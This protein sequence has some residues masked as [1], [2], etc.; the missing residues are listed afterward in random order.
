MTPTLLLYCLLSL[1]AGSAITFGLF[2]LNETKRQAKLKEESDRLLASIRQQAET[3]RSQLMVQ[4]KEAALEIKTTAEEE[5]AAARKSQLLREQK[6]DRRDEQLQQQEDSLR[7]QQRGLEMSQTRLATQ[8]RGLTDQRAQLEKTVKEQTAVLEQASGMTRDQAAQKLMEALEKELEN[9]RGTALLRHKKRL[10]EVVQAQGREMLLTAIQRYASAHTAES[11]TS[12]VDVPTDDMKGRI[13]GREGRNIRAFEKATGVDVIIDDTPGV[14][15]VSGFDPV[16]REIA[17]QSLNSLIADGR[18]HPSKI[19]EIVEETTKKI[20]DVILQKGREAADEVNVPG[21]PQKIL[22]MLGRLHFRTSYS[23]N[24]LR[25][26]VEVAF[27]SGLVAEMLGMDADL[28]RR[29]GLLHDIG[30]AA[31]HELEGGHPKI[32]ADLLRR[33]NEPAEVVHAALGHHDEIVTEYPYTMLVAIGDACSA[34][35]PGARRES[36]ERYVKRMEELES[37]AGRFDG[38]RQAFAISAGRELRVIVSSDKTTDEQAATI[39]RNIA[40]AFESELTYPGEIKVTVVRESRFT[41][42]AH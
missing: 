37:I 9:E 3:E 20:N 6:L 42:T 28:A 31:D 17:R 13:I 14:V 32:G 10:D 40:K 24:V 8:M 4:S 25:H 30:K 41:E 19:E 33:H 34:S 16:R 21:L 39:C 5:A 7:K 11:T 12:T 2:K 35:R 23:Q 1:L 38:V 27:V 36:L 15:I 18:I 26:S 22:A 29:C